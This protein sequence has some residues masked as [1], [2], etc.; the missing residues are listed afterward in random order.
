MCLPRLR[1][2]RPRST[3]RTRLARLAEHP[4]GCCQL[5]R[6][7]AKVSADDVYRIARAWQGQTTATRLRAFLVVGAL[8]QQRDGLTFHS[9][10]FGAT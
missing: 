4:P 2:R 9:I 8:D 3:A 1:P 10:P 6:A 7:A 5:C